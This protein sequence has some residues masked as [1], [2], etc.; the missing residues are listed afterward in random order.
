MKFTLNWLSQYIDVPL[1]AEE[2]AERL[3]MVGLEV[4]AV[5]PLFQDMSGVKTARVTEVASHPNADK[6]V[7]CTVE[8]GAERKR[9]VCGAPNARP[10]LVTAIALP[11]AVMPSGMAIQL[12]TI[13][14]E[15]SEGMLCSEKDLGISVEHAGIMELDD[16]LAS[17]LDLADA[18]E[19]ADTLIE[20]DLTPNRPDC[21]SVLGIARE[22]GAFVDGRMTPPVSTATE[23]HGDGLPFSVTVESADDCPRYTARLLRNVAIGSSPWWLRRRLLSVGLRPINNVVDVT[24]FIMLEYGQ[25]MHAFD[26]NEL[27]GGQIIVRC[28][29][30]GDR[31]ATLDGTERDL[32]T[33]MLLV[34]D[35]KKPVAVAGV[36]GGGDSEVSTDTT[37]ILL[38]SACFNS[39]SVRR[40]SR[41]LGLSTDSSYRFERGVDPEMAPVAMERAVQLLCEIA[42]ATA[43]DGGVDFKEGV[44]SPPLLILRVGRTSDL[45]GLD[46]DADR[47][48]DLLGSI[49]IKAHKRDPDTLEVRPPSFRIDLEREIDLVEEVARLIGYNEIP[50]TLPTVPMS[51]PER[52]K[53]RGLRQQ[54][55]VAMT[56]MGF[57]EAINYSFVG[58][59]HCDL[60]GL[61]AD[62]QARKAVQLLNPLGEEQ[63]VM[64]T[65]LLPGLLENVRRNI[66]YQIPDV[67]LFEIGKL[68]HPTGEEQPHE[69]L[70]LAAVLTG[71]R[72]PQSTVVHFG[73]EPVDISDVK[74]VVQALLEGLRLPQ[75][76]FE[77]ATDSGIAEP[78]I[79]LRLRS[80]GTQVGECGQLSV[81]VAK[82]FGIK[83]TVFYLDIDLEALVAL[84][85]AAIQFKALARF[86][87]VRWDLAVVVAEGV[88]TGDII[89]SIET[90]EEELVEKVE[91]FDIYRGKPIDQG[92]K[93]VAL[94]ITYRSSDCTL[95]DETVG[96]VHTRL[97]DLIQGR[98]QARLREM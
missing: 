98:F 15:T 11:G 89:S 33:G 40:T 90:A 60:L 74:G 42:G 3:T 22:V 6:L 25:P 70:H 91:L 87:A 65:V 94:S 88:A 80:Q 4:D 50:T 49:E 1:P 12:S 64:R 79:F 43:V 18:L 37:E 10:G 93:S 73:G 21:T 54:L 61:A 35:A 51:F 58:A 23:L 2:L 48:V 7:L 71:R 24:N 8:V 75:V 36:M 47:L 17:G 13:R 92:R 77:A 20:V 96:K 84:E 32:D 82:A 59:R 62:H 97:I 44:Q 14:G 46:L 45:L 76:V 55:A 57:Y 56:G 52:D 53:E 66:N 16:V 31:I 69:K 95:D 34:C 5:E 38:E 29:K 63:G 68:F 27:D 67:R 85:P 39:V 86:P 83:Q 19:L 28:A 72:Y 30:A 78:G 9:V 81:K 41:I 26:F